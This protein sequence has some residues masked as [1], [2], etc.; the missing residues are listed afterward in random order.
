MGKKQ[1][2]LRLIVPTTHKEADSR[3][4]R[5]PAFILISPAVPRY[6]HVYLGTYTGSSHFHPLP[7]AIEDTVVLSLLSPSL[8]GR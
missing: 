4:I 2:F 7:L 6:L 5:P 1:P 8:P 3:P